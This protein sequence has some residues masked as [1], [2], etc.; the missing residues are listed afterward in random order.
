MIHWQY[1]FPYFCRSLCFNRSTHTH[2]HIKNK[3]VQC[4]K[5]SVLKTHAHTHTYTHHQRRSVR[6]HSMPTGKRI[7]QFHPSIVF[8]LVDESNNMNKTFVPTLSS[9]LIL[10]IKK[11]LTHTHVNISRKSYQLIRLKRRFY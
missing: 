3:S 1:C 10:N 5:A 11:T 2:T 6:G 9:K 7:F 8:R 4:E